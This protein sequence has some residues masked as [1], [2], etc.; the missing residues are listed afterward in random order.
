LLNVKAIIFDLDGVLW[1]SSH[2]HQEAFNYVCDSRGIERVPYSSIAGMSSEAAWLQIASINKISF[3]HDILVD[4]VK[5]KR[6]RFLS[7]CN[8]I[9]VD[10]EQLKDFKTRLPDFPWAIVT[11]ASMASLQRFLEKTSH[12]DSFSVQITSDDNLPSKP[13]SAPY[14]K[15]IEQL[16]FKPEDVLVFEDS[17]SGILSAV[18][19]GAKVVHVKSIEEPCENHRGLPAGSILTCVSKLSDIFSGGLL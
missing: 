1:E 13:D 3:R 12:A 6:E 10:D 14:L 19:A 4:L 17:K 2:I 7:I 8:S 11:G 15:A 18:K 16:G 9:S 5:E